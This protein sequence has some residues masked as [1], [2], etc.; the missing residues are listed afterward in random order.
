METLQKAILIAAKLREGSYDKASNSYLMPMMQAADEAAE[1]VG[2]DK[3]GTY[4][5]YL[6]LTH[7]WNDIIAWAQEIEANGTA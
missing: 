3:L 1:Q 2:Y 5:I 7:S 4:P 6:L